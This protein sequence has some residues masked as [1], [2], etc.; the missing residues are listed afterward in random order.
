MSNSKNDLNIPPNIYVPA[1]YLTAI[2]SPGES[3]VKVT[4]ALIKEAIRQRP[5]AKVL[6]IDTNLDSENSYSS[7]TAKE[8]NNIYFLKKPSIH[9]IELLLLGKSGHDGVL[10]K[11]SKNKFNCSL[12][13]IENVTDIDFGAGTEANNKIKHFLNQ[14]RDGM[15]SLTAPL[16]YSMYRRKTDRSIDYVSLVMTAMELAYNNYGVLD[17]VSDKD[18]ELKTNDGVVVGQKIQCYDLIRNG[19]IIPN[20]QYIDMWYDE[21]SARTYSAMELIFD[22]HEV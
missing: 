17:R 7:I 4:Q 18:N 8:M 5:D 13:V 20:P 2:S 16:V 10:D 3:G 19:K 21:T 6:V 9:D 15:K 11:I 1:G 22:P 12:I 14:L